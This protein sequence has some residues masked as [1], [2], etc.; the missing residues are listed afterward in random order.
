MIHLNTKSLPKNHDKLEELLNE[1]ETRPELISISE[2]KFP[3]L[4]LLVMI[5]FTSTHLP[6]LAVLG[7]T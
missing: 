7:S 3:T 6:M 2:T 1:V 4:I 5:F